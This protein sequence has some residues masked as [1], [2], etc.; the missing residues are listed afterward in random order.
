MMLLENRLKRVEKIVVLRLGTSLMIS[1]PSPFLDDHRSCVLSSLVTKHHPSVNCVLFDSFKPK[2]GPLVMRS[3]MVKA[4]VMCRTFCDYVFHTRSRVAARQNQDSFIVN[5]QPQ[6]SDA[7]AQ[8]CSCIG[9]CFE[10]LDF[11]YSCSRLCLLPGNRSRD[12][13]F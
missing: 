5:R 1:S 2:L 9:R 8:W 10:K 4:V 6:L 13:V 7:D 11:V 12:H 3:S